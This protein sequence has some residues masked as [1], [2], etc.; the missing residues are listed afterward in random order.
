MNSHHKRIN[1]VGQ[2]SGTARITSK[3]F[4]QKKRYAKRLAQ[5]HRNLES[6]IKEIRYITSAAKE[7]NPNE[8]IKLL[9]VNTAT[10]ASGFFPV[11]FAPA[12][13]I[14]FS[15][16]LVEITPEEAKK[17]KKKELA[18]WPDDWVLGEKL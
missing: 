11:T 14:P 1:V 4:I 7:D 10:S 13:D 2:V 16:T 5:A 18:G 12:K 3:I 17:L 9:E 15:S 6:T 8:P